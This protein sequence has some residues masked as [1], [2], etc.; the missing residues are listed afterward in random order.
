MTTESATSVS[1]KE[2][3]QLSKGAKLLLCYI[4]YYGLEE[5]QMMVRDPDYKELASLGWLSEKPSTIHGVKVFEIPDQVFGGISKISDQALGSFSLTDLENY[6][7]SKRA[8][9]PW[10]W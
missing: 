5:I 1:I 7:L 8:S 9:Y 2:F 3:N 10:L 6:K 4:L